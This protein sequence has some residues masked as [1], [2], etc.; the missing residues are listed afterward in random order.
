MFS[1][2]TLNVADS[3]LEQIA[4]KIVPEASGTVQ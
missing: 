2:R 3:F 1:R 4:E